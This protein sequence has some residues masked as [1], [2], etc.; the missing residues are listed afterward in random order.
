M[1]AACVAFTEMLGLD[2]TSLRVDIQAASRVMAHATVDDLLAD[3]NK[4][5]ITLEEAVCN[6]ILFYFI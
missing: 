3:D 2:S 5:D 6:Y 4:E 1:C